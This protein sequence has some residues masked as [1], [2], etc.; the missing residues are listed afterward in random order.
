MKSP[1]WLHPIHARGVRSTGVPTLQGKLLDDRRI[2][3]LIASGHYGQEA[4]ATLAAK[5]QQKPKRKTI[6]GQIKNLFKKLGI[7]TK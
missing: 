1:R 5:Q 4:Q 6:E 2:D 7:S 3:Q